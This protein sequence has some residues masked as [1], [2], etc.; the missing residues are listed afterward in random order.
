M[1]T[2][3]LLGTLFFVCF[4]VSS[5]LADNDSVAGTSISAGGD[6]IK[7]NAETK[8]VSKEQTVDSVEKLSA[9]EEQGQVELSDIRKHRE[10]RLSS[11]FQIQ[12]LGM[13]G[14]SA[15][16]YT[17]P[18][19]GIHIG[20][21]LSDMFY[22]G[23]TAVAFPGGRNALDRDRQYRYNNVGDDDQVYGYDDIEK[24]VSELSPRHLLEL[25]VMPWDIGLYFSV[26]GL[27][28][29]KDKTYT[30]FRSKERTIGDRTYT[31]TL[32]AD[33]EYKEWIGA[34]TG[35]GFNYRFRNGLTLG[36]AVNV[37]LGIR[38]PEVTVTSGSGFSQ[39]DLDHWIKQIEYE[40]R[41]IPYMMTWSIGYAF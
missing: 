36:G 18:G 32:R 34:E 9:Q 20:Y 23:W 37:G 8:T 28:H 29:G 19:G 30:E 3:N 21:Q 5:V 40:E 27:Y 25:R 31:T 41:I 4:F 15:P 16:N 24:T 38:T 7:M 6:R 33:V 17:A 12:V 13:V 22:I 14:S 11:S 35:I 39:E 10:R 26:G 2:R 1:K